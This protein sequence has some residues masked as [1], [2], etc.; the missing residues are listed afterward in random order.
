MVLPA[1][2]G[3]LSHFK[4]HLGWPKSDLCRIDPFTEVPK[5]DQTTIRSHPIG[6]L[7]LASPGSKA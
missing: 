6:W 4:L 7:M 2:I 3:F 5:F 1:K